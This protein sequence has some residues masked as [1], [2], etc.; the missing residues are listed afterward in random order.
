VAGVDEGNN[1]VL[2]S[3][4]ELDV[5]SSVSSGDLPVLKLCVLVLRVGAPGSSVRF[6]FLGESMS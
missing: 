5:L 4:V 6:L 1:N 2:S 3:C